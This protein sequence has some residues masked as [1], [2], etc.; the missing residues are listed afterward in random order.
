MSGVTEHTMLRMWTIIYQRGGK[1]TIMFYT[2]GKD[3]PGPL[4]H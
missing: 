1:K 4:I 3:K 2:A